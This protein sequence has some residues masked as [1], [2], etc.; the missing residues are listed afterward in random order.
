MIKKIYCYI[1]FLIGNKLYQ[2]Y[3]VFNIPL[4]HYNYNSL[5]IAKIFRSTGRNRIGGRSRSNGTIV[6]RSNRVWI[7]RSE[8]R[9]N[10]DEVS[11]CTTWI[12]GSDTISTVIGVQIAITRR[13]LVILNIRS[14]RICRVDSWSIIS[15]G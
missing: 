9:I 8:R 13:V 4:N 2:V 10:R 5:L 6:I 14:E 7:L 12:F 11:I 15:A 1:V 3:L